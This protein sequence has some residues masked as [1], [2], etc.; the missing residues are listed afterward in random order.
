MVVAVLRAM[1][2]DDLQP[3]IRNTAA[4]E[5]KHQ[6]L[7]ASKARRELGWSIRHSLEDGL[8]RTAEWYRQFF[9]NTGS[10]SPR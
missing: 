10:A 6:Y 9:A 4:N 2:R 7:D 3:E 5:I 1:G 8:S